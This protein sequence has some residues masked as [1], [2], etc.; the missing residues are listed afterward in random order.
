[1]SGQILCGIFCNP[2]SYRQL[3]EYAFPRAS[4][5]MLVYFYEVQ[6]G[7]LSEMKKW[8]W[9]WPPLPI[10]TMSS[11]ATLDLAHNYLGSG[12]REVSP[13]RYLSADGIRQVRMDYND[14]HGRRADGP[15]I[16]FDVLY[17]KYKT[18]HLYLTD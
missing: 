12:Y 7:M 1:M 6:K 3:I 17:P 5:F 10:P 13:D 4:H 9:S 18:H 2:D 14:I 11:S 8:N 16:N 15:H